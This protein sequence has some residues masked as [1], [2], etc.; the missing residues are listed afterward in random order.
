MSIVVAIVVAY[1]PTLE[2][3]KKLFLSLSTQV[4]KIIVIDNGSDNSRDLIRICDAVNSLVIECLLENKGIAYAQNFGLK[5]ARKIDAD[6]VIY[7]DQD[8]HVKS[9]FVDTLKR[10][11]LQLSTHQPIAAVAPIFKDS[12]YGFYYPFIILDQFGFRSK[13]RPDG[14]EEKPFSVSLVISSGMFTSMKVL[15]DVG[16]MRDDFFIDYV[17]TEWCLRA[18]SKGYYLYAVPDACMLHAIGD[19]SI[20]LLRW[21]L[22]VHSA[23]RRY[24]RIRNAFYLFGLSHVPKLLSLRE[25]TFNLIHQ[26]IL[27]ST[28][29]NK[30]A[31]FRSLLKALKDGIAHG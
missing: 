19:N 10:S 27:I 31:N 26:F 15:D 29:K 6:Y 24:Y 8:S 4:D 5:I 9:D 30:A 1:N 16:E 7:F 2:T 23:F 11:F 3:I 14:N 22:P 28:Q 12:R 13:I 18:L 21:R 20:K 25:I 17:D